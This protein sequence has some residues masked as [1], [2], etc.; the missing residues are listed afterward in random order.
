MRHADAACDRRQ[1]INTVGT[2]RSAD[3]V[4]GADAEN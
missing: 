4:C 3:A 2:Y 1:E